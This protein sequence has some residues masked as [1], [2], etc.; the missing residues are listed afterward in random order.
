[1]SQGDDGFRQESAMSEESGLGVGCTV[2]CSVDQLHLRRDGWS[3]D[4][5]SSAGRR[6]P[7]RD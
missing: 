4:L 1:M 6:S 5:G 3:P 7:S 2:Q